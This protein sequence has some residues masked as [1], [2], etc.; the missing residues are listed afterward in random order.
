MPA[1]PSRAAA[2]KPDDVCACVHSAL[3]AAVNIVTL[4]TVDAPPHISMPFINVMGSISY[5]SLGLT[6]H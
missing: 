1:F 2:H 6:P 5:S 3:Y 4:E